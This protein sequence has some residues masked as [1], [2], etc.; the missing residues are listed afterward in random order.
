MKAAW[1]IRLVRRKRIIANISRGAV[2]T[3]NFPVAPHIE[4]DVRMVVRRACAHALKFAHTDANPVNAG[5]VAEVWYRG[6]CHGA[7]S[8]LRIALMRAR[9]Y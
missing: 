3:D 6:V 1:R 7:A 5:V 8:I 9:A 2:R 4:K